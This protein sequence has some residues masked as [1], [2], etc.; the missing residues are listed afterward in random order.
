MQNQDDIQFVKDNYDIESELIVRKFHRNLGTIDIPKL[1]NVLSYEPLNYQYGDLMC[2]IDEY[3][4]GF[5]DIITKKLIEFLGSG[6]ALDVD[7][8]RID[9]KHS[10][11]TLLYTEHRKETIAEAT[12][13][14]VNGAKQIRLK[15]LKTDKS[16]KE[17]ALNDK[18]FKEYLRL[19]RKF[20][21]TPS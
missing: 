18:E 15:K 11:M 13:R 1:F 16:K 14:L 3:S 9:I 17:K 5:K 19:K 2:R 10:T 21:D 4:A 6:V 20:E 8:V 7:H 12:I